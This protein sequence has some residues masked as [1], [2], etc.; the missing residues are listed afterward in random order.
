MKRLFKHPLIQKKTT[1]MPA[2]KKP[3]PLKERLNATVPKKKDNPNKKNSAEFLR[4]LGGLQI[5]VFRFPTAAE[6]NDGEMTASKWVSTKNRIHVFSRSKTGGDH[7]YAVWLAVHLLIQVKLPHLVADEVTTIEFRQ[8]HMT[9]RMLDDQLIIDK[10]TKTI[11]DSVTTRKIQKEEKEKDVK[12][13]D[14]QR[15]DTRSIHIGLGNEEKGWGRPPNMSA[16]LTHINA[17]LL[18][19][20]LNERFTFTDVDIIDGL[21]KQGYN[22]DTL[23][24]PLRVVSS[25]IQK[26]LK[27]TA[28]EHTYDIRVVGDK[29]VGGVIG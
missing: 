16:L 10:N 29:S 18:A 26:H 15:I 7:Q 2:K 11:A 14:E 3:N 19:T 23:A 9:A 12:A 25:I 5:G 4:L 17:D 13:P 1:I 28:A 24:N 20:G 21:D 8:V 6:T 27:T 22:R